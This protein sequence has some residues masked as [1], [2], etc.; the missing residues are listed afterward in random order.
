MEKIKQ[1]LYITLIFVGVV[2]FAV[3]MMMFAVLYI[4]IGY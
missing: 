2:M 4:P 3:L 1:A